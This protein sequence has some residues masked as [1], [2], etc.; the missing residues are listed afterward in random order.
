MEET[1][2]CSIY[3]WSEEIYNLALKVIRSST[4]TEN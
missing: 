1:N 4:A 3:G 2:V